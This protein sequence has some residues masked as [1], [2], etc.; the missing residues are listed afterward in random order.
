[1]RKHHSLMVHSFPWLEYTAEDLVYHDKPIQPKFGGKIRVGIVSSYFSADTSIWG[2]FGET[3]QRL[4]SHPKLDISFIYYHTQ[5]SDSITP[6]DEHLSNNPDSNIYLTTEEQNQ[7][8]SQN[9]PDWITANRHKIE[10]QQ[11]DVLLYLDMFMN[12]QMNKMATSKLAPVQICTHGHPVTS[13]IPPKIM[14]YYLSWSL[15]ELPDAQKFYTEELYL[16]QT[17]EPWE[18]YEPRTNHEISR[19]SGMPFS[20]Y[21][22]Q[23]IDFL[24]VELLQKPT[25]KWY[26]CSQAP[27]KFSMVFDQILGDILRKDSNAVILLVELR[28]KELEGMMKVIEKRLE[29]FGVDLNRIV[30][31]PRM[32]HHLL[33]AMYKLSDV[34]LDS[35]FF[36]GDT[37]TREALEVGAPVITYPGKTIGQRWTQAY[38]RT[39]GM[40]D[41]IAKDAD[42]YVKIAVDVANLE[43]GDQMELRNRIRSLAQEKLYRVDSSEK[44]AE[45]IIDMAERPRYWH[46]RGSVFDDVKD[47]L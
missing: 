13:G 27:F 10:E 12:M 7:T 23:N 32:E 21:T 37:T 36:G 24:D 2:N 20:Q 11:F 19:I 35:V 30:F 46:W 31:I 16:I 44:W 1:L 25:A 28:N 38:Y 47:E 5:G 33:M 17:D 14:D 45:A 4:Q 39:M 40:L 6:K 9:T 22:R 18:Y 3:I 26:F 29:S 34:I 8:P 41:F 43:D 42:D 15:A